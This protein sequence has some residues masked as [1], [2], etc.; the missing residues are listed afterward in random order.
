MK[1]NGICF[2]IDDDLDDQEI[3]ALALTEVKS[4]YRCM[5]ANNGAE[6]ME[7]LLNPENPIPDYI[8]LDLNMS[9]MNGK[10]CL[11]EIKRFEHLRN[12]PVAIYSTSSMAH[13]IRETKHLGA[14]EFITKPFSMNELIKVLDEFFH[15]QEEDANE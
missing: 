8:F 15:R 14:K 7:K 12:I 6:A 13:D 5:Y 2:L 9:K 10:E 4:E 11:R 1:K 3:F